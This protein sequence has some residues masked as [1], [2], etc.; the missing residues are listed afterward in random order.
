MPHYC[1][2]PL[3]FSKKLTSSKSTTV[4]THIKS[5]FARHGIP[6]EVISDNGPQYSSKESESFSKQWVFKHTTTSP[7]YPQANGIIEKSVQTVKNL[8]P[9]AKQGN[10]DP[11]LGLLEYKKTPLDEVALPAQLLMSRL[12]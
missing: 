11:C 6:C 7:L 4:I 9:K 8:L 2:L 12:G 3:A 5:A 1:R 10:R